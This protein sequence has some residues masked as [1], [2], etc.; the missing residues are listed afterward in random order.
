VLPGGAAVGRDGLRRALLR[1]HRLPVSRSRG[2]IESCSWRA[3]RDPSRASPFACGVWCARDMEVR[4]A[5][6]RLEF[7]WQ[8][9]PSLGPQAGEPH[10]ADLRQP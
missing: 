3:V 4:K 5:E 2:P 8:P 6:Q 9:S 1:P 7:I 10:A